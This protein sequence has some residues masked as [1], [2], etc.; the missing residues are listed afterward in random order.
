M[1]NNYTSQIT[2]LTN[3]A[4]S[5]IAIL[6]KTKLQLESKNITESQVINGQLAPDMFNLARQIGIVSDNLKGGVSRI[7]GTPNPVYD[8]ELTT[9]DECIARLNKT[10]DYVKS[11]ESSLLENIDNSIKVILPWMKD[12]GLYLD[13]DHY[14]N[15]FLIPNTY[16][17]IV[18]A[19]AIIRHLGFDIAKNDFIGELNFKSVE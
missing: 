8:E 4:N 1:I 12:K 11:V 9:I 6:N 14:V 15:N 17:H 7:T 18:I 16:F 3:S 5:L 19:Y 2:I 10:V 13:L